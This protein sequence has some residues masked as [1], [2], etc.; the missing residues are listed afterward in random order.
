MVLKVIQAAFAVAYFCSLLDVQ[1]CLDGL[2]M[3]ISLLDKQTASYN[4]PHY[5]L[6]GWVMHLATVCDMWNWEWY[7]LMSIGIFQCGCSLYLPSCGSPPPP[8]PIGVLVVLAILVKLSKMAANSFSYPFNSWCIGRLWIIIE[9][10]WIACKHLFSF[11]G[12][13]TLYN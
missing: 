8:T 13:N 4:S 6:M 10:W 7:Q 11:P 1:E 2:Y 9:S 3:A 12:Y 5:W